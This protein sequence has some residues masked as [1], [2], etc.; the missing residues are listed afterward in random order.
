MSE[1]FVTVFISME[2]CPKPK[3]GAKAG[4]K[5][6]VT[7]TIHKP[8]FNRYADKVYFKREFFTFLADPIR[9]QKESKKKLRC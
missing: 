7:T 9:K 5:Y 4:T 3:V 6:G 2:S 8:Q 1:F